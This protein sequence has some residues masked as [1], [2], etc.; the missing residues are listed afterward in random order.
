MAGRSRRGRP[1]LWL[2][3]ATKSGRRP[4]LK[5]D[6]MAAS[7]DM[8]PRKRLE[9]SAMG[10]A[11]GDVERRGIECWRE[12]DAGAIWEGWFYVRLSGTLTAAGN[13]ASGDVRRWMPKADNLRA[14]GRK[15]IRRGKAGS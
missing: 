6:A 7:E 1:S 5:T 11:W 14:R 8:R 10:V 3:V 9:D 2:L 12:T 15:A 4:V 13:R